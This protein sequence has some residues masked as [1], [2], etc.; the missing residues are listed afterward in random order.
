VKKLAVL[1]EGVTSA[2]LFRPILP[3]LRLPC[4]LGLLWKDFSSGLDAQ[5]VLLS[6]FLIFLLVLMS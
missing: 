5:L 4:S 6:A 1:R 2:W 3:L